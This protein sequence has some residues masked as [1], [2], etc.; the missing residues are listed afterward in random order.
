MNLIRLLSALFLV[1]LPALTS[2]AV[3]A[4]D[5]VL[6]L[7]KVIYAV[8][9][10][11]TNI[12]F[13]SIILTP[14]GR[15][16]LLKVSCDKGKQQVERWVITPEAK[17]VGTFPLSVEVRNLD[18]IVIARAEAELRIASGAEENG[19][20]I[21]MLAIG[22]SLTD[23]GIYTA[24]VLTLAQRSGAFQLE[25]VGTH[26][27]TGPAE[28]LHEG[29]SGWKYEYFLTRFQSG[30]DALSPAHGTSPF[31]FDMNGK[32]VFDLPRYFKERVSGK[33]PDVITIFLG[34]NDVFAAT[35]ADREA[36]VISVLANA[37]SL[38]SELRKAAPKAKIGILAP[39][40]P[41][42]Q[43]AFGENCGC[44]YD[45]WTYR[46]NQMAFTRALIENFSDCEKEGIFFVPSYVNFD[47]VSDYPTNGSLPR[48]A[49]NAEILPR[50]NNAVHPAE[51]GY[52]HVAD[53]VYAWLLNTR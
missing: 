15:S 4:A 27:S 45:R 34:T 39:L 11:E 26:H 21:K 6:T 50:Q 13:S 12:Y 9:G 40:E 20:K 36:V 22:D 41:A 37:K 38:V 5:T 30:S 53:A 52:L 44:A 24:E 8:V 35:D 42:S 29:Y 32:G 17:D 2:R 25:L 14:P 10:Q 43:D 31:I 49:R 46:K 19:R 33:I 3:E 23:A 1:A 51:S 18:D 47:A 28:N 7:T 16:Y 48:N